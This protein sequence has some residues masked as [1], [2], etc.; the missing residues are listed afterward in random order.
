[1]HIQ[2]T[3]LKNGIHIASGY[4]LKVYVERGHLIVHQGV[5]VDRATHRFNR[6]TSGLQ[7]LVVVGRTG[8]VT[9]EALSWIRDVGASFAQIGADGDV[10]AVSSA[11]RLHKSQLRRAQGK[12]ATSAAG[13]AAMRTLIGTKLDLQLE[14]ARELTP[15]LGDLAQFGY[16]PRDPIPT[17]IGR[18]RKAL[19]KARSLNEIRACESVAGRWYWHTLA[20]VPTRFEASWAEHV[21]D[22]WHWG[23]NRT[24]VLSGFKSSRK[25]ATPLHA[26]A[27]YAYAI[28]ETEAMIVLQAYGFDPALGILHTDKRYRGSLAHDLIEPVRPVADRLVLDLIAR[29]RFARGE[30]LETREGACRLGPPLA[31]RLTTWAS[32]LRD[33]LISHAQ[34]LSAVIASANDPRP[35]AHRRSAKAGGKGATRRTTPA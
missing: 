31:R 23:G 13:R 4:G 26:M 8:Y 21:P 34:E 15:R 32:A 6:A 7:R 30:L 29:H 33:P 35:P 12:A 11:E 16:V 25:A 22:H 18:Q 2:T 5:G 28:L 17:V 9:F 19:D 20:H 24:T 14:T 1:M 10:I 27:N 3:R